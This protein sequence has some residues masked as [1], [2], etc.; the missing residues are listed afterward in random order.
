[1]IA[2]KIHSCRG[3]EAVVLEEK[4]PPAPK[5]PCRRKITVAEATEI[6]KRGEAKWIVKSRKRGVRSV[7]CSHCKGGSDIKI[8]AK[9]GGTGKQEE[10]Y[11]EDIPGTDIV[12]TSADSVDQREK[13][14]R[15]WLAPKTPRVATIESEH[16]SRAYLDGN[17]E[18]VMRIEEY[19]LLTVK[20]QLRMLTT[21]MTNEEFDAAW[22]EYENAD[23]RGHPLLP[24]RMEPDNS[25]ERGEGRDY[26]FGRTI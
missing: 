19:G 4:E 16:I 20:E 13:K 17:K 11:V 18:A 25:R 14:K 7:I 10:S 22:A 8:C 23:F 24:I 9:C 5:C 21:W 12:Y 3:Q 2:S 1:M 26:D 6:V 15:K